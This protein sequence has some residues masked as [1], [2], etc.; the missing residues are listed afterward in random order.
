M[1][2]EMAASFK[3]TDTRPSA[4]RPP[5]P[6]LLQTT[7]AGP[8]S[9]TVDYVTDGAPKRPDF[10]SPQRAYEEALSFGDRHFGSAVNDSKTTTVDSKLSRLLGAFNDSE[11]LYPSI[12]MVVSAVSLAVVV[13]QTSVSTL[14][15]SVLVLLYL[16]V[17]VTTV[18]TFKHRV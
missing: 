9:R 15:K 18:L 6:S 17:L 14:V 3:T 10:K 13:F 12:V 8:S 4:F 16:I 5:P 1:A 2:A 11:I 7:D